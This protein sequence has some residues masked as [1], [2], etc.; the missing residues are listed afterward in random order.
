V[1]ITKSDAIVTYGKMATDYVIYFGANQN[2]VFTGCNTVDIKFYN[3]A[4]ISPL[5][6]D[7]VNRFRG[8]NILYV[9]QLIERKNLFALLKA[10]EKIYSLGVNLIVVGDGPLK[11]K[12]QQYCTE[13]K[14]PNIYFEGYKQKEDLLEYYAI[15][16]VFVLPSYKEVWGLVVNEALSAGLLTIISKHAGAS[17]LIVDGKNGYKFDPGKSGELTTKL[18]EAIQKIREGSIKKEKISESI[19]WCSV[20][21]YA[22]SFYNAIIYVPKK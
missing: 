8:I 10:F 22:L 3:K 2:K 21:N 1:I 20:K 6:K 17:E 11:S 16:Q 4:I 12:L 19:Y 7:F 14:I 18:R 5:K 9:G 15:S 13:N